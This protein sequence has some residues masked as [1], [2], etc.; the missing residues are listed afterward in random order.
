MTTSEAR[1]A[2]IKTRAIAWTLNNYTQDD[3]MNLKDYIK[4]EAVFGCF[5]EEKGE[6]GTPHLQGYHHYSSQRSYPCKAFRELLGKRV[7]DEV[8]KG[9]PMQNRNY[10]AGLCEKKGNTLNDTFWEHGD[11]PQQG[12]RVDWEKAVAEIKTK[13]VLEVIESQPHL[14]PCVGAI[15][16]LKQISQRSTHRNINVIVIVG[17]TGTGKSRS[18]WDAYPDLYSKPTGQWWDGYDG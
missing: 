12:K 8:A 9:S 7:H 11:L 15:Q 14:A 16:R 4:A 5:S 3:I 18:A 17:E 1:Q 13:T 2:R 10:C 6:N